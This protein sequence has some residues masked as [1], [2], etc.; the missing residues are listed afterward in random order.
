MLPHGVVAPPP[1]VVSRIVLVFFLELY[2]LKFNLDTYLSR[3]SKIIPQCK[4]SHFG[5]EV[6]INVPMSGL[7]SNVVAKFVCYEI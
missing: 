6:Y 2:S 3:T 4:T 1:L 5:S 7:P